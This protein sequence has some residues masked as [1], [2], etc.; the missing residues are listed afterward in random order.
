MAAPTNK[1]RGAALA[2]RK[3]QPQGDRER[4]RGQRVAEVVDDVGQQGDRAQQ[5]DE[6]PRDGRDVEHAQPDQPGAQK[7]HTFRGADLRDRRGRRLRPLSAAS[8]RK[9]IDTLARSSTTRSR[10]N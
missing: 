1:Q 2:A 3:A 6:R 9:L 8:L 7:I 5:E 10:I 4:D